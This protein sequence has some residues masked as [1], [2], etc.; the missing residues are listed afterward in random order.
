ADEPNYD[1]GWMQSIS[2]DTGMVRS[3]SGSVRENVHYEQPRQMPELPTRG[4]R[5]NPSKWEYGT[6]IRASSAGIKWL[7]PGPA[8]TWPI[9]AW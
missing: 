4:A 9:Y 6:E 7:T 3:V 2:R 5:I 8:R 1:V